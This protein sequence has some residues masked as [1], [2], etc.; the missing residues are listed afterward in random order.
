[1]LF[2]KISSAFSTLKLPYSRFPCIF[3]AF[4]SHSLTLTSLL[5]MA[6]YQKVYLARKHKLNNCFQSATFFFLFLFLFFYVFSFLSLF[7]CFLKLPFNE[8][9]FYVQR[10]ARK[11]KCNAL[12]WELSFSSLFA[13]CK[14]ASK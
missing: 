6:K 13:A 7:L 11:I 5:Q 3:T 9:I 2:N 1:M 14:F 12:E 4:L 8:L 10:K